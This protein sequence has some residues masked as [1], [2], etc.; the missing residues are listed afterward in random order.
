[1]EG[2]NNPGQETKAPGA[3]A[4]AQA[5]K[6][7][8]RSRI[9]TALALFFGL[10]LLLFFAYRWAGTSTY[11]GTVQRVYEKGL[12]YRVEFTTL[13]G[14]VRV[15]GNAEI[16]FPYFKLDTA[17]VHANLNRL[18]LTGDVVDLKVWGFRQAW[19][20]MFPNVVDVTFVRSDSD[21]NRARAE[22]IADAVIEKLSSK[23]ILKGG[24]G[25]R[26]DII[27]AVEGAIQSPVVVKPGEKSIT[28]PK[29][30]PER[31]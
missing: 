18:S 11:R 13:E 23:G 21:R 31:Q 3:E 15:I 30:P 26:P 20:D 19:F 10:L 6:R 14:E 22:R 9:L 24:E 4:G 27:E 12:E 7:S 17:D 1:M 2:S 5:K 28:E 8:L 29:E 25:L 16:R